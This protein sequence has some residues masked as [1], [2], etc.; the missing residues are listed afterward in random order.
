MANKAILVQGGDG[1]AI[2]AGMVGEKIDWAAGTPTTLANNSGMQ[3]FGGSGQGCT[4]TKGVYLV[5]GAGIG[6]PSTTAMRIQRDLQVVSGT[7]TISTANSLDSVLAM[8]AAGNDLQATFSAYVIVTATAVIALFGNPTSG[9]V[10]SSR[11][12]SALAIRLA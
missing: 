2:P 7:A 11:I 10:T 6:T 1:T 12:I 8:D 9:T 4:L 3:R 5:L